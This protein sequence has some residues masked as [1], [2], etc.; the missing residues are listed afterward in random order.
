VNSLFVNAVNKQLKPRG[1]AAAAA[2]AAGEANER[3]VKCT[4]HE[5][6]T[7][8]EPARIVDAH[9]FL[10]FLFAQILC[11]SRQNGIPS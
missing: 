8:E 4:S 5:I 10:S 1:A 9:L 3:F 6:Q 2:A 7:A 11:V